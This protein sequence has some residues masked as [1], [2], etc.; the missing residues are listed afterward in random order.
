MAIDMETAAVFFGIAVQFFGAN[1]WTRYFSG[2]AC[3]LAAIGQQVP[4]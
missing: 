3:T 2:A 4:P 1:A